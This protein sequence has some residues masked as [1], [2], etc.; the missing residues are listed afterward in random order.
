MYTVVRSLVCSSQSVHPPN[1]L[2][3]NQT[4]SNLWYE[5]RFGAIKSLD[6]WQGQRLWENIVY[7]LS[8]HY[9]N[10][11]FGGHLS[12]SKHLESESFLLL[13]RMCVNITNWLLHYF[14]TQYTHTRSV[15]VKF[16]DMMEQFVWLW[17]TYDTYGAS[18]FDSSSSCKHPFKN[19]S[20]VNC[21]SLFSSILANIFLARS[22]AESAGRF[23]EHAP[24]MS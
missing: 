18:I 10:V 5:R 1:I 21:P 20:W 13:A 14:S 2:K 23:D 11:H 16:D 12:K 22:S 3:S 19:S 17:I 15:C 6:T 24:N 4:Q 7:S 8:H 9:F